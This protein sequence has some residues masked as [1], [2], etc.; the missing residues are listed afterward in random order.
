MCMS[1]K[2]RVA[3]G[4]ILLIIVSLAS[5]LVLFNALH[6]NK[7]ENAQSIQRVEENMKQV[8]DDM[9]LAQSKITQM[10]RVNPQSDAHQQQEAVA[11]SSMSNEAISEVQ[12]D[13]K[14]LNQ[15]VDHLPQVKEKLGFILA[16]KKED[17]GYSLVLDDVEWFSA[18]AAEQAAAEDGVP[19]T[20]SLSNGFYIRN[21]V[22]DDTH[23]HLPTDALLYVLDGSRTVEVKLHEMVTMNLV[24]R[25][26]HVRYAG[27]SAILLE[28]QYRP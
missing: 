20:A 26:F 15:I 7:Q 10:D 12:A 14:K 16:V 25:L 18:E 17:A 11:V 27:D 8:Q 21:P 2:P 9:L 28:E 1:K 5:N 24:D 22:T 19:D 4:L 13:M 6:K 3:I 23:L